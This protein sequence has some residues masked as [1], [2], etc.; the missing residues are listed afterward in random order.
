M[1]KDIVSRNAGCVKNVSKYARFNYGL[2][3]LRLFI[4]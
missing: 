1:I 2:K 3:S 4:N